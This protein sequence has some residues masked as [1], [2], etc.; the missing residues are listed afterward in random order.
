MRLQQYSRHRGAAISD[1]CAAG[2]ACTMVS[3][4]KR[5]RLCI[6]AAASLPVWTTDLVRGCQQLA[7]RCRRCH[8]LGGSF[9]SHPVTMTHN[10]VVC[11]IKTATALHGAS[12]S[13]HGASV[14]GCH[15]TATMCYICHH[16]GIAAAAAGDALAV[17]G[18]SR[19]HYCAACSPQSTHRVRVLQAA[20]CALRC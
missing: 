15:S 10:R 17:G 4:S 9:S 18:G 2:G 6:T 11:T 7:S 16:C 19:R 8:Q 1:V 3:C 12:N 20:E 13:L 14:P 5:E